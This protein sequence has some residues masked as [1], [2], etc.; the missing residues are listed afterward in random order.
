M[1]PLLFCDH[2]NALGVGLARTKEM[3]VL[4][5]GTWAGDRLAYPLEHGENWTR[6][7]EE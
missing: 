4:E 6:V 3:L 1:G 5:K 7:P 2:L